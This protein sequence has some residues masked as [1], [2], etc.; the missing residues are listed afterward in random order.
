MWNC[1]KM[2]TL[3]LTCNK[4]NDLPEQITCCK[5]LTI[6]KAQENNLTRFPLPW[7]CPLVSIY[8]IDLLQY[9]TFGNYVYFNIVVV[10]VVVVVVVDISEPCKL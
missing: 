4:L 2:K 9:C 8:S 10:V 5:S 1:Q 3:D 7:L 6:L